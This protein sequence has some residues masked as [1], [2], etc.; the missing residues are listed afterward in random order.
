MKKRSDQGA[1]G[2]IVGESRTASRLPGEI[3]MLG[4]DE[5]FVRRRAL[6]KQGRADSRAAAAETTPLLPDCRL[7]M[8]DAACRS[9]LYPRRRRDQMVDACR[10]RGGAGKERC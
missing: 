6:S 2:P 9:R 4:E 7:G 8:L 1:A 3:V 5:K 10:R